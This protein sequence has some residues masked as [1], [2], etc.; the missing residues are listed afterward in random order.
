[1]KKVNFISEHH[2]PPSS[3]QAQRLSTNFASIY[4]QNTSHDQVPPK[5][6]DFIEKEYSKHINES[7]NIVSDD[8]TACLNT[9]G[10]ATKI[11][12]YS[13]Q[14]K[15]IN[16]KTNCQPCQKNKSFQQETPLRGRKFHVQVSFFIYVNPI[17]CRNEFYEKNVKTAYGKNSNR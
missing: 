6:I 5:I 17:E 8:D 12:N 7:E 9:D 10:V 2:S 16:K 13:T 1:M 4:K 15:N 3:P 11:A 14:H